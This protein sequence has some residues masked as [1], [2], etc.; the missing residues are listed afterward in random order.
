MHP[1]EMQS[2]FAPPMPF[3]PEELHKHVTELERAFGQLPSDDL[4]A[5]TAV[6]K[7]TVAAVAAFMEGS[8]R[9]QGNVAIDR[10]PFHRPKWIKAS[11]K[12]GLWAM[13]ELLRDDLCPGLGL[14]WLPTLMDE[15]HVKRLKKLRNDIDHGTVV[16]L[17]DLRMTELF[18]HRIAA[19]EVL[20][21]VYKS[22]GS[23]RPGWW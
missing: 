4:N 12:V 5:R 16:A 19:V 2:F 1:S 8:I 14:R 11:T 18:S 17:V 15:E 13:W 23:A 3:H 20:A 21:N 7:A 10:L 6:A 22:L 9:E